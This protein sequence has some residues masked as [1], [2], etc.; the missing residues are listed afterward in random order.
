MASGPLVFVATSGTNNR[1]LHMVF[2][3]AG[4]EVEAIGEIFFNDEAVGPLDA[5]GAPISG[6][7]FFS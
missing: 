6:S 2:P 7:R 3:L 5:G 1:D 4:H